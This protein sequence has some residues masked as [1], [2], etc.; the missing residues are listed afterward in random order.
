M[1]SA[2]DFLP[3]RMIEFMN[4]EI[5]KSLNFGSGLTS[6]LS[7]LCRRDIASLPQPAKRC[8]S[9][10]Q[11]RPEV[12]RFAGGP[13]QRGPLLGPLCSILGASLLAVGDPLRV[14]HAADDV[15]AHA[16]KVLDPA[17]ADHHHRVL[18]QVVTL[19]G[20]VTD[21]LKA[22]GQA[23]LG[24][25]AQRRI[26][27]LRRRG[28]DARADAALLRTRLHVACLLAVGLLRPRLADQLLNGRH[29]PRSLPATNPC[30]YAKNSPPNSA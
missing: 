27:L 2:T 23:Y 28:I 5:T 7:A 29:A 16:G 14:E 20:D 15:V 22:I 12:P 25:L 6:R 10:F 21:H 8:V 30:S 26:R 4:L 3:C 11:N 24:N 19:A 1:R 13:T 17:A 9:N 18:L